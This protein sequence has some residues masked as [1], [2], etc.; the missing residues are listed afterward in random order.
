MTPVDEQHLPDGSTPA[1]GTFIR[2][3]EHPVLTR[4][5]E[6]ALAQR[7][8]R[9][10]REAFQTL[11]THNIRLVFSIARRYQGAGMPLDDLVQEGVIGLIRAAEKFDWRR[12]FKFSTYATWWI[13]Q[14]VQR[15]LE[16]EARMIRLP[17]HIDDEVYR[18]RK[19]EQTLTQE[20]LE[21]T[22]EAI[23]ERADLTVDRVDE[24]RKLTSVLSLD[25]GF[26]MED[27]EVTDRIDIAD[28]ADVAAE[29]MWAA[30]RDQAIEAVGRLDD[31]A[32]RV[33]ELRYGLDGDPERTLE[34][35]GD[36]LDVTRE[37]VRQIL[38]DAIRQV[39]R[40][41][42]PRGEGR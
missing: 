21:V 41:V 9:G 27:G 29:G 7:A 30:L 31:R 5:Q 26:E 15:G 17:G 32:R 6:R 36:E 38:D 18:M 20:G 40:K 8:E 25:G 16:K 28:Q 33:I 23:A 4:E 42:D 13:R 3:S 10:D 19:A 35:I 12:G 39:A 14:A 37:R 22:D 1:S 34:E 11:V 24:L 2:M